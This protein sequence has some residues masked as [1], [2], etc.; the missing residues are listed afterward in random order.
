[1]NLKRK[2]S[3]GSWVY[4]TEAVPACNGDVYYRFRKE[5]SDDSY[6]IHER[7]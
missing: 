7:Y 6:L 2:N 4:W 3:L 5:N 1:M